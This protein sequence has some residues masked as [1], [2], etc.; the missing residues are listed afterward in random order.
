M[1]DGAGDLVLA[2]DQV[3]RLQLGREGERVAA[4]RAEALGPPRLAVAGAPD[5][6]AARRA[7]AL[8]LRHLGSLRTAL[9]ASTA[10]TGGI[11]VR[12]APSRAPRS[13]VEEVPTRRV[14]LL[15]SAPAR[16]EPSAVVASWSDVRDT[17]EGDCAAPAGI[18][19]TEAVVEG[20]ADRPLA[21]ARVSRPAGPVTRRRRSTRRR[22]CPSSPAGCTA[23]T[24]QWLGPV[25]VSAAARR[26]GRRAVRATRRR[27]SSR[28]GWCRCSRAGCRRSCSWCPS[29]VGMRAVRLRAAEV[30]QVGRHEGAGTDEVS[31]LAV[32]RLAG[33]PLE[34]RE[35][36]GD[37]VRTG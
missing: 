1:G 31:R 10:G 7:A 35:V 3:A 6:R 25:D 27:R 33:A 11:V 5:R 37:E 18:V 28:R 4:V 30:G 17:V 36:C 22:S 26:A 12:P 19:A 8:V 14:T 21:P 2:A 23:R 24:R 32:Q 15:P 13:R 9:A 16:A 20:A 29:S 34:L